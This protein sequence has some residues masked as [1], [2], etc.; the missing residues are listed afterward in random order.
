MCVITNACYPVAK[1]FESAIVSF[2]LS[3]LAASLYVFTSVLLYRS[4][5]APEAGQDTAVYA[6]TKARTVTDGLFTSRRK[7]ALAL[8][9][10]ACL[11]HTW[12]VF[13]QAG[14]PDTLS[15][16]LFTALAATSLTVVFLLILLSLKCPADYLG[17]AVYPL[18]ALSIL[19]SHTDK[20]N[21]HLVGGA[22]QTHAFLSLVA[23]ALLTLAA[24]QAI[25]VSI[26]RHHLSKH[27]PGGFIRAL[28][29]LDRTE[30]LLFTLL[31]AGFLL[32]SLSLLSGFVYLEDMF[33]QSLVHKTILSCVAWIIFAV[34][35]FG[36]WRFGWRGKK[37]VQWALG[38]FALLLLAYFGSKIMLEIVLK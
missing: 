5:S 2:L 6:D 16:P 8:A 10:I 36:R 28:P 22:I 17:I 37:A 21:A 7:T 20:G 35:L 13:D 14:F 38:G 1:T 11:L 30:G 4:V 12:V 23:Y 25:L 3:L 34:L 26:Q 18:A 9:G 24:A 33:A 31:L 29:A 32:L 19:L 27:K 15:L